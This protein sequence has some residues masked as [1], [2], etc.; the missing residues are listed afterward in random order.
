MKNAEC[1]MQSAELRNFSQIA[2]ILTHLQAVE[3]CGGGKSNDVAHD[4]AWGTHSE[5]ECHE[6]AYG[7]VDDD[8]GEE[9]D[10][11]DALDLL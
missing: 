9:G 2:H 5:L 3:E 11:C 6:I 8:I 7:Y 1:K 4:K 10:D